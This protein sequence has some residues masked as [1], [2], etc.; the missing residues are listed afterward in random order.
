MPVMSNSVTASMKVDLQMQPKEVLHYFWA[1]AA[2][3]SQIK[4]R[5]R[6]KFNKTVRLQQA[7]RCS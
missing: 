3:L 1:L 6:R 7:F 4:R 2:L 5:G